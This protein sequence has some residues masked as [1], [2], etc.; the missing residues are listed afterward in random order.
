MAK[1][2]TAPQVKFLEQVAPVVGKYSYKTRIRVCTSTDPNYVPWPPPY[3]RC[4]FQTLK[5]LEARGALQILIQTP[6]WCTVQLIPPAVRNA[7]TMREKLV[8]ALDLMDAFSNPEMI[9]F[10]K[11][12][13]KFLDEN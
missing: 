12:T 2:L 6:C 9:K 11:K 10:V 5:G 7:E 8:E 3:A 4:S 13:R 1:S